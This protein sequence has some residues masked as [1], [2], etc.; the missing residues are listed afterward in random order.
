[1]YVKLIVV[2]CV[3]VSC[4]SQAT[5]YVIPTPTVEAFRPRGLRVSIPD[6]PGLRL[7]AFHGVINRELDGLEA[8]DMSKDVLKKSNG[9]WEFVDS[10]VKLNYGDELN[11]W[12]FVINENLGYRL[13][14]QQFVITEFE[15]APPGFISN[16]RGPQRKT[17]T[18]RPIVDGYPQYVPESPVDCPCKNQPQPTQP[19]QPVRTTTV[20]PPMCQQPTT[21]TQLP[22]PETSTT[23]KSGTIPAELQIWK[24]ILI[25]LSAENGEFRDKVQVLMELNSLMISKLEKIGDENLKRLILGGKISQADAPYPLVLS[26]LKEKLGIMRRIL[27]TAVR[28]TDGTITFEVATFDD[29][30]NV[31]LLAKQKLKESK[32]NIK[33]IDTVS[34]QNPENDKMIFDMRSL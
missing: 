33:D 19:P 24:D 14:N 30:L 12:L 28:N 31:L 32:I 11:F 3:A 4:W 9:R 25:N 13:D 27:R 15:E 23:V 29:K 8:G 6:S 20:P 2:C 17:T 34:F 18:I 5:P 16:G 21:T 1:M 7:F 26:V 10:T 22:T